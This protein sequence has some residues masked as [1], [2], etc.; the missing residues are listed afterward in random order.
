MIELRVLSGSCALELRFIAERAVRTLYLT[1]GERLLLTEQREVFC[2]K[3]AIPPAAS[4]TGSV[5]REQQ[6]RQWCRHLS[7]LLKKDNF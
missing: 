3:P 1:V 6:L 4:A 5:V 2:I 7:Y